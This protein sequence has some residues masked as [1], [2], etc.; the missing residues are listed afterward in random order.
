MMAKIKVSVVHL[1]GCDRCAWQL[2]SLAD[3]ANIEIVEHPFLKGSGEADVIV[4]TGHALKS[5]AERLKKYE[6]KKIILYGT[7]PYS[8]GIFGLANQKITGEVIP[9]PKLIETSGAVLGCPPDPE[10]LLTLI[11]GKEIERKPLCKECSR[12]ISEEKITSIIRVPNWN[13]QETCFNNQGLPCNGVIAATCAQRCIDFGTPCRGCVALTDDPPG[14][15]IGYFGSLAAQIEVD[16]TSTTWTTDTLGDR[17]D[18]LTRGLVDVVGTFFR[19]HLASHFAYSGKNPSSGDQLSDI[20]IARAIEEA[21][22][23]SATIFGRHGISVA[24]NLIEAYEDAAGIKVSK[25][26]KDL[27]TELRNIQKKLLETLKSPTAEGIKEIIADIRGIGGNEVLSNV[28]FGGFKTPAK[29]AQV[30]FDTYQISSEFEIK[31]VKASAEDEFSKVSF[32][33]DDEGII[34]EWTYELRSA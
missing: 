3:N 28:Y 18:D 2:I 21:P 10:E 8:G 14:R 4:L 34:R 16:T 13:N 26:T 17:P 33:T 6:G 30:S 25:E 7:C 19:F 31:A 9:V 15:M 29:A 1:N 20:M 24:L 5:D 12:A 27:R 11:A 32:T 23:I 22:Q